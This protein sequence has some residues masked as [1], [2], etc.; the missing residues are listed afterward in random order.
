[1][2][3]A[4]RTSHAPQEVIVKVIVR[5]MVKELVKLIVKV[6]VKLMATSSRR[7][8]RESYR[9]KV[10]IQK[11]SGNEVYCTNALLLL[12]KIM[13]C[14]EVHCKI[15]FNRNCFPTRSGALLPGSSMP[16]LTLSIRVPCDA[17]QR[18]FIDYKTSMITDVNPCAG[19]CSTRIPVSLSHYT[20]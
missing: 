9:K 20:F 10:S 18:E 12:M 5:L 8:A 1:M 17:Q 13:L 19:S 11:L 14:S 4:T 6:V 7:R 16:W 15:F 2:S 3:W